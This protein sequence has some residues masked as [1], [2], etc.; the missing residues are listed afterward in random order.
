[1]RFCIYRKSNGRCMFILRDENLCLDRTPEG[2]W[3]E[4]QGRSCSLN[5]SKFEWEI[6]S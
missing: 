2:P 5:G 1:M 4:L 6:V 3:N